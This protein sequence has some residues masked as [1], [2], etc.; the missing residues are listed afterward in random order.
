MNEVPLIKKPV[1]WFTLQNK[2]TGFYMIGP[3]SWPPSCFTSDLNIVMIVANRQYWTLI[4]QSDRRYFACQPIACYNT[5][6]SYNMTNIFHV[7]HILL[8]F[9]SAMSRQNMRNSENISHIVLGTMQQFHF[10]LQHM[11]LF[12]NL[13]IKK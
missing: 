7:C 4:N 8:Y 10:I 5:F 11:L 12:K 6:P 1:R 13:K 2:W 3:P 9:D